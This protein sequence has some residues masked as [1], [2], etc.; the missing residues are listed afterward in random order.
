[1]KPSFGLATASGGEEMEQAKRQRA[2]AL[3]LV[4]MLI[5]YL[6]TAWLITYFAARQKQQNLFY[7]LNEQLDTL[8]AQA[9][10]DALSAAG[11]D[12]IARATI[13]QNLLHSFLQYPLAEGGRLLDDSQLDIRLGVVAAQARYLNGSG[14]QAD[15]YSLDAVPENCI[16]L[17]TGE[18]DGGQCI[19]MV[20]AP[21]EDP[22]LMTQQMYLLYGSGKPGLRIND[23]YVWPTLDDG[24]NSTITFRF[25]GCWLD[26]LFHI[27][28]ISFVY[29]ADPE[30]WTVL[31]D[32][33]EEPSDWLEAKDT[34]LTRRPA[35]ARQYITGRTAVEDIWNDYRTATWLAVSAAEQLFTGQVSKGW[36]ADNSLHHT[37][38]YVLCTIANPMETDGG[39][40]PSLEVLVYT[41]FSPLAMALREQLPFLGG[42]LALFAAA[43]AVLLW[44]YINR[45]RA[46]HG[47]I[48]EQQETILQQNRTIDYTKSAET[49]RRQMVSAI[50]HELKTPLAIL[51]T[52][53]E[54]LEENID[55]SKRPH[56][57]AVIRQEIDSMDAMVL[58]MLDLSRLESGK[59]K[60]NRSDFSLEDVTRQ[61]VLS[62]QPRIDEK[63][64]KIVW[65]VTGSTEVYADR[66]RMEQVIRNYM[67]NAIRHTPSGGTITIS[68][69]QNM[70][71]G[72][73]TLS[74]ENQ[75]KPIPPEQMPLIWDSFYQGDR[76]RHKRGTGL[77]LAIVKNVMT[78]HGGSYDCVNTAGG[79]EFLATLPAPT[80]QPLTPP[81]IPAVS[82]R[83]DREENTIEYPI[84]AAAVSL[85]RLLLSLELLSERELRQAVRF[86][87]ITV[88]GQPAQSPRQPVHPGQTVRY[89]GDAIHVTRDAAYYAH[90]L[91]PGAQ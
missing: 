36:L 21:S 1:M 80:A 42:L 48:Q 78:L 71:S 8:I 2:L 61:V 19:T 5:L 38:Y 47:L 49:A 11:K 28:T 85:D 37:V 70:Y 24:A 34:Q 20:F 65:N 4:P 7:T 72:A 68:F 14:Y 33:G 26:G 64:V 73:V 51:R 76:S 67:T 25:G 17:Q 59:Y 10:T 53:N 81:A 22:E 13:Y 54:A 40:R 43:T 3:I 83:V 79:V 30:H 75:G 87:G 90:F 66:Y 15:G 88:D 82:R 41:E 74:V 23:Y 16:Q 39:D 45:T 52:Y 12:E 63:N 84:G 46:L 89:G 50:A 57:Q 69:L 29:S 55:E 9:Q 58:Q 27:Q 31:Y 18:E 77:G 86:G 35:Y 91:H 56:Y 6:L 62:L 32:C 44:Y 60:L